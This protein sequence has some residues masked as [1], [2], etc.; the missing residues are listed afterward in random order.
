MNSESELMDA[1]VPDWQVT[2]TTIWCDVVMYD[3]TIMIHKD[4]STACT[5]HQRWGSVRREEKKG[6]LRLLAQL[7]IG[8]YEKLVSCSCRGPSDCLNLI[9]FREQLQKQE[10]SGE[11][12]K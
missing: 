9:N 3:T 2:A 1:M 5:Y 7:G 10:V 6:I 4:W 12:E 8:S 11:P